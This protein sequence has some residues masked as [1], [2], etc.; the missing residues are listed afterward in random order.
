VL[1][2]GG[3]EEAITRRTHMLL[4]VRVDGEPF[5][6]DVGFGGQT[7]TGPLRLQTDIAQATPHEDFRLVRAHEDFKLQ[8]RIG[9]AWKSLYRFD[10][11]PQRVVDY[12]VVSYYLATHPSSFFHSTLRAARAPPGARHALANNQ[13]AMHRLDGVTERRLLGSVA[14][15]R[16]ALVDV[17]GLSLPAGPDLDRAIARV[18]EF[19]QSAPPA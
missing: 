12:D 10:L 11:Q 3:D 19:P 2:G 17:F 5:I 14:E 8:S 1:W 9:T 6:A 18:C 4:C 15:V 16:E 13:L 7:L